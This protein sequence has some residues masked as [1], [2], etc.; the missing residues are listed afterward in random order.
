MGLTWK[1]TLLPLLWGSAA[2]PLEAQFD[3][4]LGGRPVQIHSFA[5]QGFAYSNQNNYL[6][7]KTSRGTFD[8][9]DVGVNV[10]IQLTDK[11]RIGAQAYDRDFGS[12]GQWHPQLDW[13]VADYRFKDWFGIRG[14]V[15]K[16][17]F[18]LENDTQ[19]V[20]A[21]HTFALLPQSVYPTDLRDS[22]L[23]HRGGDVYGDIPL[24]RLGALAY[25]AYAGLRQDGLY[26]GYPYLLSGSGGHLTSYGGLQVGGDLRWT[27]P[28]R[29]LLLGAS[30]AGADVSGTGSWTLA[31]PGYD[32][33]VIPYEEHSK[34][35]WTHQFYGQYT[36]GNWRLASEY[37]RYWR[38]QVTFSEMWEVTT[39]VRGWYASASYRVSKRLELGAY[40]SRWVVSWVN[41]MP[42]LI[43]AADQ[44]SPDRHLYDKV[45]TARFDLNTHWNLKL[46]GHFMDGYGGTWAYPSGFYTADNAQGL[47]PRTNL[48]LIRTGWSF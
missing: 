48:L 28:L 20:D 16:T 8:M 34:R 19:D 11:L 46:E 17:V 45:V 33:F 37:R 10:S 36:T 38:D 18:G 31:F 47:K 22:L 5:S 24:K 21:L 35:D 25:T 3:F 15:V 9:T 30:H 27:T 44:S 4:T 13:A 1:A 39:D 29:G 2:L 42:G 12:L 23:R 40:Y 32:P 41:T 6:T 26:G 43:P 14:G 7:M